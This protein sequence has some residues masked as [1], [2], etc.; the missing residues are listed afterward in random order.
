VYD[1]LIADRMSNQCLTQPRHRTPADVV[2]WFGA[3]QAQEYRPAKWGLSLR[4]TDDITEAGIERALTSGAILRTHVLRPTWHFVAAADIRWMLELTGP[5]IH[6]A[7]ASHRR[8]LGLDDKTLTR[9]KAVVERVLEGRA[10]TRAELRDELGRAGIAANGALMGL[11]CASAEV[12]A[13]ICSGPRRGK[14]ATYALLAE[15]SPRAPRR[16]RDE[17]IGE[18]VKRYF[19]SHGPATIADFVWWSGLTV[20][21]TKRGLEMNR[22]KSETIDGRNY[23]TIG[24]RRPPAPAQGTAYLLPIYDEYLVAYRDRVAVPHGPPTVRAGAEVSVTFQH[25]IIING[26]VAGTWRTRATPSGAQADLFPTRT[27]R[28]SERRALLNEA[29]RYARFVR[30]SA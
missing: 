29:E 27:L 8:S 17:S 16:S 30:G 9:A 10:L 3:V 14:H 6:R 15:R 28:V 23:W 24:R 4:L 5:R 26:R 11:Y 21:E 1:A 20:G 18:L 22:A 12:E 2:K 25:A 7:M 19:R 13:L